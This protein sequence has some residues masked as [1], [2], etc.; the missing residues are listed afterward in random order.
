M[1]EFD[2][3]HSHKKKNQRIFGTNIDATP[4]M[5]CVIN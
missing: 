1:E 3:N 4:D 5:R 2:N